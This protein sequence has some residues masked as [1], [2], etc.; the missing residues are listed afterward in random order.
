MG[1]LTN[2]VG[3]YPTHTIGEDV[4]A[5][6]S[7]QDLMAGKDPFIASIEAAVVDQVRAGIELIWSARLQPGF[8]E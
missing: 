4:K 5:K 2:T 3:S 8:Q 1:I 7:V 6:M